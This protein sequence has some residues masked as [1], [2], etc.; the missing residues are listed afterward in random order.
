MGALSNPSN[1]HP[2]IVKAQ[3]WKAISGLIFISPWLLGFLLLKL[4]PI[5]AS[6]GFSFTSFNM[7]KP[8]ETH[9]V[10]LSNY[11]HLFRDSDAG[12]SLFSTLGF[13]LVAIPAQQAFSLGLAYLLSR[14]WL[15]GKQ[16][17]RTLF[18]MPAIIPGVAI[19]SVWSGFLDPHTGWLNRLILEP[20]GLPPSG[21]V[22]SESSFM[23]LLIL[24]TLW[25]IGPGMII[26]LG[27]MNSVPEELYE[28]ARVD[29]AG[30]FMRLI[31][32]TVP[33]ISPAI[34]FSL[35]INLITVFGGTALLDPGNPFTGGISIID[36]YIYTVMYS[37]ND[38]G[39]A[40]AL[41][42][43]LFGIMMAV[44]LFIFRTADRWVY[45]PETGGEERF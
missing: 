43:V 6:L 26:M 17:L 33:M 42:W 21:G 31:S 30:P 19:F 34:L 15:K 41:A 9:F 16:L 5:L 7:I 18:F 22:F 36:N 8:Q 29:G 39:Y 38:L 14:N 4:A 23:L 27:S 32:I 20:L 44:T 13:A 12:F 25:S 2:P 10:G 24:E 1:L 28:A 35:V 40:S 45:Y 3:R 37:N 11:L